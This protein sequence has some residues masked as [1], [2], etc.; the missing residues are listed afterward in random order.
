MRFEVKRTSLRSSL[1]EQ[2]PPCNNAHPATVTET[3]RTTKKQL[4]KSPLKRQWYETGRNHR[5]GSGTKNPW[6]M[7]EVYQEIWTVYLPT[8]ESLMDFVAE[9]GECIIS[10]SY[11]NEVDGTIEIYDDYRE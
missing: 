6:L 8:Y 11:Y 2:V 1:D 7:R 4:D 5:T 3:L 9:H 10:S